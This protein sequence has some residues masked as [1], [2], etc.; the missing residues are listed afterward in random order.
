[1]SNLS[2]YRTPPQSDEDT[3][4][5]YE[6]R[7]SKRAQAE[8]RRHGIKAKVPQLAKEVRP[9]RHS[10]RRVRIYETTLTGYVFAER[11]PDRSHYVGK[12]CGT[13]T[14]SELGR[15][16]KRRAKTW[17]P[18]VVDWKLGDKV[19]ATIATYSEIPGVI[20]QIRRHQVEIETP[21][22][23]K[24]WVRKNALKRRG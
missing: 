3:L 11:K 16:Y 18:A 5:M 17:E 6:A 12:P 20:T 8:L 14:R 23:R 7:G 4:T 15:L 13:V 22:G 9:T 2:A 10:K 24:V 21:A 19:M 1:M